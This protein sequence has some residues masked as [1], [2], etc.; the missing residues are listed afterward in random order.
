MS[1]LKGILEKLNEASSENDGSEADDSFAEHSMH[2]FMC[3][4][5]GEF[6]KM[7]MN[8]AV[9][10]DNQ[11][12]RRRPYCD[13]CQQDMAKYEQDYR[14]ESCGYM[15]PIHGDE[16][17]EAREY[18]SHGGSNRSGNSSMGSYNTSDRSAA[19]LRIVGKN[20]Y[21]LQRRLISNSSSYKVQQRKATEDEL[22]KVMYAIDDNQIPKDVVLDAAA[23]YYELQ[24]HEIRRGD[25]RKG[26]LAACLYRKCREH[27]IDRKPKKIAEMFEI[28]QNDLS[29]GEKILD[30]LAAKNLINVPK[31]QMYFDVNDRVSSFTDRYFEDLEIPRDHPEYKS[32]VTDLIR[33]TCEKHVA[34][35]SIISSKCAGAIFILTSRRS[36]LD[37][38]KE[39]IQQ[40]CNISKSTFIRF[41]K[42]VDKAL[43]AYCDN[44][45]ERNE[46]LKK[47]RE[48]YKKARKSHPKTCRTCKQRRQLRHIFNKYNVAIEAVDKKE[49]TSKTKA[50]KSTSK[51]SSKS[52]QSTKSTKTK[53]KTV[54]K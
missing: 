45:P 36:E 17:D 16:T 54:V 40:A 41:V 27:G 26:T 48:K 5:D 10:D 2:P 25:V 28:D 47:N 30:K 39:R 38:T 19:P 14:C 15:E 44:A 13:K 20:A 3:Y 22:L 21:A 46:K 4:D 35:S 34:E 31:S 29:G 6:E 53:K 32:F 33:F 49:K 7:V 8:N 9:D 11:V 50:S 42:Q 51:R 52:V 37:I 23:L 18:Y 24:Q 1:A 12:E 43:L